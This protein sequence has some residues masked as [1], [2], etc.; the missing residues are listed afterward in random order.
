M[1]KKKKSATVPMTLNAVS[2]RPMLRRGSGKT[3]FA[4]GERPE[5]AVPAVELRREGTSVA[6]TFGSSLLSIGKP[7][8][9]VWPLVIWQL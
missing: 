5:S 1:M 9:P 2:A 3:G 8:G 6:V 7:W 4:P